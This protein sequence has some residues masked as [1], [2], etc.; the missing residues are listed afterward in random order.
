MAG[1]SRR[2]TDRLLVDSTNIDLVQQFLADRVFLLPG[3]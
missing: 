3:G 2:A 1:G